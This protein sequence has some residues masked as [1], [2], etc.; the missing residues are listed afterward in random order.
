VRVGGEQ[1]VA[2]VHQ[3]ETRLAVGLT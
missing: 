3:M 1:G 2:V